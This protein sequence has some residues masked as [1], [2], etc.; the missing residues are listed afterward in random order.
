M[1]SSQDIR[2]MA[3]DNLKTLG[4]DL[5]L[6]GQTAT[7]SPQSDIARQGL[8][9]LMNII[10][11]NNRILI[12]KLIKSNHAILAPE[13]WKLYSEDIGFAQAAPQVCNR[14]GCLYDEQI[15][16]QLAGTLCQKAEMPALLITA[17][18]NDYLP[19]AIKAAQ[20]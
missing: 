8:Q 14:N 6:L 4:M 19:V 20:S 18:A 10:H 2:Q 17:A 12:A 5:A 1:M 7:T 15:V 9:L 16:G 11:L 13:A 3:F